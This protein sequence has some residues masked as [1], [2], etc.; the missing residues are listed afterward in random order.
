MVDE[1]EFA[2]PAAF[3]TALITFGRW[4]QIASDALL[5]LDEQDALR[6]DLH[7]DGGP[8][9][10]A[11]ERIEEDVRVEGHPTRIGISLTAP[12]EKVTV[13]VTILSATAGGAC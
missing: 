4:Q 1:V 8:F 11:E 12:V 7:V 13:Q 10:I 3:G 9:E 5:V 2:E 6:V